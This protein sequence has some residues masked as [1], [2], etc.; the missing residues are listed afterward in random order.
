MIF[1][2]SG[3]GN[4]K[5]VA[6]CMNDGK[7]VN[8][9]NALPDKQF[10]Y[11]VGENESVGFVFPVYY[12]GVPKTVLEFVRNL[13]LEGTISYLYCILTHGGGPGGA[14]IMFR[15]E[16]KKKGYSMN[17]C[18][19]VKFPSNYIRFYS[20][21]SKEANKK[22][23]QLAMESIKTIAE[24]VEK[25]DSIFPNWKFYDGPLSFC[26]YPLCNMYMPTRKFYADNGCIGCGKCS[27][28]C[29]SR[30][31][32]MVDG[33]PRWTDNKCV[34]CMGCLKCSHVQYGKGTVKRR[35]YSFDTEKQ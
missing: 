18:F 7:L 26:M 24:C 9:S 31:I 28:E 16:L 8:I 29:P 25:R 1:Y 11:S 15:S 3:T 21:H 4:S 23:I 10:T 30:I 32:E 19:D 34:R 22:R 2:F 12:S 17:A 14:G 13:Q 20:L 5:Y 33:R 6:K 27:R 35:R